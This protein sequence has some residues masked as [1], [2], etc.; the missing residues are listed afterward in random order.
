MRQTPSQNQVKAMVYSTQK[1]RELREECLWIEDLFRSGIPVTK[2]AEEPRIRER[3]HGSKRTIEKA[4]AYALKGYTGNIQLSEIQPYEGLIP[5]NQYNKLVSLIRAQNAV[6]VYEEMQRQGRG[7]VAITL[8]KR[9]EMGRKNGT[10]LYKKGLGI[11]AQTYEQRRANLRLA[12]IGRG[13]TPWEDREL[14]FVY[15]LSQDSRYHIGTQFNLKK[16]TSEVN[17]KFHKGQVVRKSRGV[18]NAIKRWEAHLK[19][20]GN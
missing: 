1:G 4:L 12:V 19:R 2:I 8:E 9:Q 18:H 16:L 6:K 5:L 3:V 17:A 10:N 14:A 7:L 11:H 15:E 13:R 20:I